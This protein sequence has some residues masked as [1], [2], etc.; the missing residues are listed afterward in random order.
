MS[1]IVRIAEPDEEA[2]CHV[3]GSLATKWQE[4][5][6]KIDLGSQDLDLS[7]DLKDR[8][9]GDCLTELVRRWLQRGKVTWM[10]VVKL[11]DEIGEVG[12]AKELATAKCKL[13]PNRKL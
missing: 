11:L 8:D 10:E 9:A 3:L 6:S 4:L 5:G 7:L 1:C 2:L 13:L 12:K